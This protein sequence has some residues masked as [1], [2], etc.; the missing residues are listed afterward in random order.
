M[1]ADLKDLLQR[2]EAWPAEAQTEVLR[3]LAKIE[4]Q[5]DLFPLSEEDIAALEQSAEDERLGR[6]ASDEEIEELF[7]RYRSR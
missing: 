1:N 6:F 7:A 2:V 4:R 3:S 5:F